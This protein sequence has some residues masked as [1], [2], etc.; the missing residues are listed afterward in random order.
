MPYRVVRCRLGWTNYVAVID[1]EPRD[2][3]GRQ[4]TM[5]EKVKTYREMNKACDLLEV[6]VDAIAVSALPAMWMLDD[7]ETV[8]NAAVAVLL[9][10][11]L[12]TICKRLV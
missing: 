1:E 2:A 12:L 10:T 9:V 4:K 8:K 5:D 6:M 7:A 3:A 11:L